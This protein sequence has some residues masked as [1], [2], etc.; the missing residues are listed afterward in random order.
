MT[1]TIIIA[2]EIGWCHSDSGITHSELL[3]GPKCPDEISGK[4]WRTFLHKTPHN[5]LFFE[6]KYKSKYNSQPLDP[7]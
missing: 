7:G 2:Y 3:N 4:L 5:G 6:S 1:P